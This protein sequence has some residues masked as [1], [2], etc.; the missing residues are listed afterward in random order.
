MPNDPSDLAW[1]YMKLPV[2][3]E[4]DGRQWIAVQRYGSGKRRYQHGVFYDQA[5]GP[6]GALHLDKADLHQCFLGKGQPGTFLKLLRLVDYYLNRTGDIPKLWTRRPTLQEYA[7]W[8]LG[9]DCNGFVGAWFAANYPT[10]KIDGN[11]HINF[12]RSKSRTKDRKAVAEV[13][14]YDV[15]V[16][17]GEAGDRHIA[18]VE[19]VL[20]VSGGEAEV[21]VAQSASSLG[22]LDWDVFTLR[23]K[24]HPVHADGKPLQFTLDGYYDFHHLLG[25]HCV[26]A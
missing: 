7:G 16:R 10:A 5:F 24:K 13:K 1:N 22:G 26:G 9:L 11:T 14:P 6:S 23:S 17:T 21:L 12:W 20:G 2:D 18:I 8:Y 3:T 19:D 25:H 15:L 4:R